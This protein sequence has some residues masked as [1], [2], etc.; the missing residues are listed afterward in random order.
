MVLY[1]GY[2]GMMEKKVETVTMGFIGFYIAPSRQSDSRKHAA[3]KDA[4]R[5]CCLVLHRSVK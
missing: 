4:L 2:I 1:R 5:H 3:F